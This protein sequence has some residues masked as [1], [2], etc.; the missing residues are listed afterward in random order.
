[1]IDAGVL[2][3]DDR[4]ELIDGLLVDM[5]PIHLPHSYV[6]RV[7]S[8]ALSRLTL[9]AW[10]VFSQQP[11]TLSTSEPQ[12]DIAVAR[13]SDADY[14]VRH[15][16]PAD[17]GLAVEV[18]DSSSDNDRKLKRQVYAAAG[19]AEYWIVN[20]HDRQIETFRDPLGSGAEAVYKNHA[21][22][23]ADG[24]LTVALDGSRFGEIAVS[25]IL[26]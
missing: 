19:I 18:A 6:V 4:V 8:K 11:I 25:N 9:G 24:V 17:I 16:G 20:L 12:P 5:S 14:K 7:L 3:G 13:G 15:P 2:S 23:A 21:I 1:M 10:E 26:P 22:I